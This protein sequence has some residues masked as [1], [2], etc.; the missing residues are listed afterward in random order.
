MIIVILI[1]KL[2][3]TKVIYCDFPERDCYYYCQLFF[4]FCYCC[5]FLNIL[6]STYANRNHQENHFI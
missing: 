6:R 2:E 4:F 3:R 1:V 5:N